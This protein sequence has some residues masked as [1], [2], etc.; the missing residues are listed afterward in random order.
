MC[1]KDLPCKFKE[2][3]SIKIKTDVQMYIS[4][5]MTASIWQ[6]VSFNSQIIFLYENNKDSF[7]GVTYFQK[8]CFYPQVFFVPLLRQIDTPVN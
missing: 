6:G 1:M 2:L 4:L 5:I 7:F 3:H 8:S